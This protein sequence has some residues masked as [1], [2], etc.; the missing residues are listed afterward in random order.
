MLPMILS[1]M[2]AMKTDRRMLGYMGS[3]DI[4]PAAPA[5]AA[6][7]GREAGA[8]LNRLSHISL[9]KTAA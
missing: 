7:D 9:R 4:L 1:A 2:R 3:P 6:L 5:G 8:Y